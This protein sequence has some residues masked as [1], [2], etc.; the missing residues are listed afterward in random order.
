MAVLLTPLAAAPLLDGP[1]WLRVIAAV[2]V[3]IL[4]LNIVRVGRLHARLR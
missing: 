4:L 2:T 3:V 1:R